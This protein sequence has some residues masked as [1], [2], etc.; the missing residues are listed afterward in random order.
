MWSLRASSAASHDKFLVQSF[1]SE[2]RVLGIE[3]AGASV[4]VWVWVNG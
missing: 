2:T 4:L 3:G 1:I